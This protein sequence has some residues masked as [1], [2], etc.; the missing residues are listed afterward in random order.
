VALK[1]NRITSLILVAIICAA[2]N[3]AGQGSKPI[4]RIGEYLLFSAFAFHAFNGLRLFFVE[5]GFAVG[6]P[7]EPVYPYKTSLGV[8][9]PLF[10][11]VMILAAIFFALL[12]GR[13]R[14]SPLKGW[15]W[16][17]LFLGLTQLP[18]EAALVVVGWFLAFAW[19][20]V[21]SVKSNAILL[22]CDGATVGVGMGQVNRM[23]SARLS[24]S[25]AGGR[26]T[27]SVAAS[28]AFFPF[29][30]GLVAAAAAGATAAIQPGGSMR[31]AEVIAAADERNLAMAFTGTRHF[32]H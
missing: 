9:R 24:V 28:D 10:V 15:Q 13:A 23:D 4:F 16:A 19:R 2:S 18:P 5:M 32:R 8:Q 21:R 20:A 31:D 25:R 6:K 7:I 27:G 22:A 14:L 29:A 12:L 11:A 17:L 3:L 26:A 1:S 30:D